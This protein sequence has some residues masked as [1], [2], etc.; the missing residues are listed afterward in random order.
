VHLPSDSIA[1]KILRNITPP[2]F[3]IAVSTHSI[4]ELQ[5][6]EAEGTDLAVF[7]PVFFTPSKA[8]YGQPAGIDALRAA[9]QAVTIPVLALGGI[10]QENATACIQAGAAGIAAVRM[11]QA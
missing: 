7:G 9:V 5:A 1:P 2:G 10:T 11:F 4:L 6:A 3:L 8:G